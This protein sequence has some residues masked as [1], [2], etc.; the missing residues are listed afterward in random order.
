MIISDGAHNPEGL[1]AAAKGIRTYFP[2]ARVL[3]LVAVMADKDYR[4]MVDVLAPLAAEVFTLTPDNP[5]ALSASD[6]AAVWRERGIKATAFD[7]VKEAVSAAV[8][9]AE[10]QGLPLFSLGSLY[11]YAEVTDALEALGIIH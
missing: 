4:G 11:M 1:A 7:T 8:R 2:D 6:F 3:L 10:S 5:R 9:E